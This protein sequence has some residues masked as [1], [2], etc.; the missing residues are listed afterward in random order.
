MK[1]SIQRTAFFFAVILVL[2]CTAS[3]FAQQDISTKKDDWPMHLRFLTGPNGGQW[4]FMGDPI[5]EV[6]STHVL[7]TSSRVGGG[8]ANIESV[9]QKSG[10][11]GF[12]LNCFLGA[13]HSGEEEY[14]SIK[15]D[16]TTVLA[17]IYPQVLYFL[18]RKD[19]AEQH[20]IDSV[21]TLLDKKMPLRFASL[22]PGTASEF[23]LNLILKHGYGTS[24]EGL[25]AQGWSIAFNN[26][27]E[28]ADNF[29]AGDLDCF[30]YTAGTNVPLIHT[31]EEHIEVVI[32][33]LDSRVLDKLAE[34]FKTGTY[35][36]PAGDYK[37]ARSPITTL[38]DYTSI[39]VRKD[40]PD[41][42]VYEITKT[43]WGNKGDVEKVIA[44][45]GGLDPQTAIPEGIE[46]HPGA[47]RFWQEML[48]SA[49]K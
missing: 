7:P 32:L 17:N 10:D 9:N 22:K 37:S 42:L 6:L 24:F 12:T 8:V 41:D 31:I 43:L 11:L 34:K 19:F 4:F 20:G 48:S 29:V 1:L 39:I 15:L 18:L 13:A 47:L 27:A 21:E 26:Y 44:D 30:A 25:E 3:S 5:A 40:F 16:N 35:V 36:I 23:I 28:T 38:G 14:Q 45:F 49:K 2:I 33:P 46:V